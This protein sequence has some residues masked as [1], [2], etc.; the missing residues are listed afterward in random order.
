MARFGK[1]GKQYPKIERLLRKNKIDFEIILTK[2]SGDAVEIARNLP[3][4]ENDVTIAAGGDGICNE[5]ANGLLIREN[6][7]KS[8]P[9]IFTIL[10]IG[11]V[12]DLAFAAGIP[13]NIKKALHIINKGNVKPLDAGLVKGGRFPNGRY[14]FNSAGIGFDTKVQLEA[15]RLK[16]KNG[17]VYTLAALISIIRFEPSPVLRIRYED[18]E[19]TLPAFL[20]SFMNAKRL[21][22]AFHM[23]TTSLLDDGLL[24]LYIMRHQ[25]TRLKLLNIVLS[26]ARGTHGKCEGVYPDIKTTIVSVDALEG[27]MAVHCDG[28]IVCKDGKKLEVS[29]VPHA[30]RLIR[31]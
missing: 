27:E 14:F 21:G 10:P 28:E 22:G 8:A 17:I 16:I 30:L 26:C 5:V 11:R 6:L 1:A 25:P 2:G 7:N 24:D 18:N 3:L 13:R 4:A 9:P 29:C 15:N 23:G 20:V 31:S 19:I 12:N